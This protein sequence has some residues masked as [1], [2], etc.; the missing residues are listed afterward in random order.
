MSFSFLNLQIDLSLS[1]LQSI[2][3]CPLK[4]ALP[5]NGTEGSQAAHDPLI[6]FFAHDLMQDYFW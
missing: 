5:W 6:H 3:L 4:A 2:N 1:L